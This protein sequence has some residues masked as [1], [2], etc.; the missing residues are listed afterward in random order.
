MRA[1]LRRWRREET[2][3]LF[4]SSMLQLL[5]ILALVGVV[6]AEG[7]ALGVNMFGAEDD[8][9]E[10]AVAGAREYATS[11]RLDDA[12]EAAADAAD[13]LGVEL[14]DVS[15]D[16]DIVRVEVRRRADT[17]VLE[18]ISALDDLTWATATGRSRWR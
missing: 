17:L 16:E 2:G 11:R 13:E 12:R 9:R 8:A 4:D 14:V 1:T 6:I 5:V 15:V 7:V 18:R 3:G 10:V